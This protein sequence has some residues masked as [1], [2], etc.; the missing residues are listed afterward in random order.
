MN[1]SPLFVSIFTGMIAITAA[2]SCKKETPYLYKSNARIIGYDH[3][4]CVCCDGYQVV[5]DGTANPNGNAF[6]LTG[7]FTPNFKLEN[8]PPYPVPVK[9]DW[10][11]DTTGCL[12]KLYQ[13]FKNYHP[14]IYFPQ[15]EF[16]TGTV[17]LV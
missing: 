11:A 7:Y 17:T 6:F 12:R 10:L 15:V 16:C 4:L 5:I 13:Y 8:N 9:I 1:R 3:R 2:S 14:L